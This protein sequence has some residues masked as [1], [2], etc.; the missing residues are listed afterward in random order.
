MARIAKAAL[1]TNRF[2]V[3]LFAL[4]SFGLAARVF[5]RVFDKDVED[6]IEKNTSSSS[7]TTTD[8]K[9]ETIIDQQQTS[10]I[11]DQQQQQQTTIDQQEE[12]KISKRQISSIHVCQ[13]CG[14]W[15][16]LLQR[17]D[18]VCESCGASSQ[19][20]CSEELWLDPL[21]DLTY[22]EK[23]VSELDKGWPGLSKIDHQ[24]QIVRFLLKRILDEKEGI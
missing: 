19:C 4:P 23:I 17:L 14:S 9:Q 13:K 6:V 11:I 7:T 18:D 10:S 20:I 2:I 16:Q 22:V 8:Q 12:T 1:L 24:Y 15:Q 21:C 3:P 5:V